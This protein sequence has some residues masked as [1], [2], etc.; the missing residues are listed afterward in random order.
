[1]LATI[2]LLTALPVAYAHTVTK[3][4]HVPSGAT[5]EGPGIAWRVCGPGWDDWSGTTD[6]GAADDALSLAIGTGCQAADPQ[7]GGINIGVP[8]GSDGSGH[9]HHTWFVSA[10]DLL[11]ADPYLVVCIITDHQDGRDREDRYCGDVD[12]RDP[13]AMPDDIED[14]RAAGCGALS[15]TSPVPVTADDISVFVYLAHVEQ[16]TGGICAATTGEVTMEGSV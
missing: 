9:A 2:M 12:P 7:G 6:V 4:Y 14:P 15:I 8:S 3:T 1:M 10:D 13:Y 5:S 11:P 16:E